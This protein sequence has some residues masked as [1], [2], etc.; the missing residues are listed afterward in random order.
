MT[1]ILAASQDKHSRHSKL[2]RALAHF[3]ALQGVNSNKERLLPIKN[4]ANYIPLNSA[5]AK[6]AWRNWLHNFARHR[7]RNAI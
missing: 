1:S 4:P 6:I 3:S 7:S 2:L 5:K